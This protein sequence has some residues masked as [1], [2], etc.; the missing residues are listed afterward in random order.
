MLKEVEQSSREFPLTETGT[1]GKTSSKKKA[2]T[3]KSVA[4]SL[5]HY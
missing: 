3:P 5:V 1:V 4:R 2:P